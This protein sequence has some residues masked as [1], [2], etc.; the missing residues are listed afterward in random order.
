M[1]QIMTH[2]SQHDTISMPQELKSSDK[3]YYGYEHG[4]SNG[5]TEE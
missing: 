3:K 4:K 5:K 2:T 1:L